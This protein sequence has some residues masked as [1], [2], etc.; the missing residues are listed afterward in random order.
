MIN[1]EIKVG[2]FW[3]IRDRH[4]FGH[5]YATKCIMFYVNKCRNRVVR[6]GTYKKS[7]RLY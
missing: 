5:P 2:G 7:M 4:Y 3:Q 1:L 6:S